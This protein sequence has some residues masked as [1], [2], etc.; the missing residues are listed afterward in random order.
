MRLRVDR[1]SASFIPRFRRGATAV[2]ERRNRVL[3][4]G[5]PRLK[6]DA[7]AFYTRGYRVLQEG[8]ATAVQKDANAFYTRVGS[9]LHSTVQDA[10]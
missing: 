2:K 10:F 6:K 1:G 7:T 9:R 8:H 5:L 3:P 4:E